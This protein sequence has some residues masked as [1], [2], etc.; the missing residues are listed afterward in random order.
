MQRVTRSTVF[1]APVDRVWAV[2]RD[3]NWHSGRHPAVEA[4]AIERGAS[5]DKVGCVRRFR[6]RD[7]SELRERLLALSDLETAMSYCLLETPIPLFNYV[8]HLRLVPVT[9]GD[10]CFAQW[11]GRF[12][13]PSGRE[14]ELAAMVGEEIYA[15]GFEAVRRLPEVSGAPAH[16]A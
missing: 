7:G 3:F 9:D 5:A 14:A 2:L 11:E 6:L 12:T 1:D 13:A 16:A 10:R 8:A 4:G 15:A